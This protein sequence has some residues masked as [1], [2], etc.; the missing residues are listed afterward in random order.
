[1]GENGPDLEA[2]EIEDDDD[3]G[4]EEEE[5]EDDNEEEEDEEDDKVSEYDEELYGTPIENLRPLQWHC[6]Y[7]ASCEQ[8]VYERLRPLQLEGRVPTFLSSVELVIESL[9][10]P[11]S[12][13]PDDLAEESKA[14]IRQFL[15]I[16]GTL[17]SLI[18]EDAFPALN[19][20]DNAPR[21]DWPKGLQAAADVINDW[22]ELSVYNEDARPKNVMLKMLTTDEGTGY[23]AI[24]FDFA[25][26]RVRREDEID[27][28]WKEHKY[29]RNEEGA[30]LAVMRGS[31]SL[32]LDQKYSWRTEG[33]GGT[34]RYYVPEDDMVYYWG[35][36]CTGSAYA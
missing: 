7:L 36:G 20:G 14:Q 2:G 33:L 6:L 3:E 22:G 35:G 4:E 24:A 15:S 11:S 34:A 5:V 26:A 23:K 12:Q 18:E 21:E 13:L 17:I 27:Q 25:Q 16:P 8:K 30:V 19:L 32:N 31:R 28:E 1:M 10:P 9:S 29:K